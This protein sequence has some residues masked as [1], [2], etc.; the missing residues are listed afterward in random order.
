MTSHGK[1]PAYSSRLIHALQFASHIHA[2]QR[3]KGSAVPYLSHLLASDPVRLVAC[4]DKLHNLLCTVRD[5]RSRPGPD[6]WQRFSKGKD[7]QCWYYGAC[8]EAFKT[9][10]P[11]A[12][13]PEYEIAWREFVELTN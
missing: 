4:A 8:L 2:S 11:P 7:E 3:R 5:L 12:M 10:N 6:Y 13:L 1:K 9:G